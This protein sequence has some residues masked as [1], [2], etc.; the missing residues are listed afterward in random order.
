MCGSLCGDIFGFSVSISGD[1]L[2]VGSKWDDDKGN[3]SG[4]AYI[5][6]RSGVSWTLLQ[7]ITAN[8]GFEN[9]YFGKSVSISGDSIVVGSYNDDLSGSAYTHTLL[10]LC[11]KQGAC[12]CKPGFGGD[13]CST[14]L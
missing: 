4:S 1:T 6:Q 2:V 10:P 11:T 9:D 5:Y 8:D 12:I 3:Q 13:D 7:K 14:A